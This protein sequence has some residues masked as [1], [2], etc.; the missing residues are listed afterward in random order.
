MSLNEL[1]YYE[2]KGWYLGQG[3]TMPSYGIYDVNVY[4]SKEKLY[5]EKPDHTAEDLEEAKAWVDRQVTIGG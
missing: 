1:P 5:A 3:I 4:S 2:Y